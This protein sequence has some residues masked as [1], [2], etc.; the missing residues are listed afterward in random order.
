MLASTFFARVACS[1]SEAS[2]VRSAGESE[3]IEFSFSSAPVE[4]ISS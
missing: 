4:A 1:S 2:R 3:R